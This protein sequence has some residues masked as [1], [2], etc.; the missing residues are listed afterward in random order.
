VSA[1]R[2]PAPDDF[3]IV[4]QPVVSLESGDVLGYEALA[5]FED[6][7]SPERWLSDAVAAGTSDAL[8]GM[9]VRAALTAAVG[10]P[11]DAWLAVKASPRLLEADSNVR[12]MLGAP[13][14][15]VVV[16]VTEPTTSDIPSEL[17]RLPS[18][19]PA[20]VSLAVEH[21]GVT[22]KSLSVL[23]ELSPAYVKLDRR[24]VVGLADDRARQAQVEALVRVAEE[25]GCAVVACGIE[26]EDDRDAARE[27]GVGLGQGYLIG[28]PEERAI[29]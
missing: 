13:G 6:G 15:R 20:N 1:S 21:V 7:S 11:S 22:H 8:E 14:R 23:M 3:R 19:L 16:E 4:F 9:L 25:R 18:L 24:I 28:H 2:L 17:R 12:H 10:L 27:Q 5:R 29:V 26:R